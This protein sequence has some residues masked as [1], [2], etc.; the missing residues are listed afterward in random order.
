MF[1]ALNIIPMEKIREEY[2]KGKKIPASVKSGYRKSYGLMI[3]I[4]VVGFVTSI[5]CYFIGTGSLKTFSMGLLVG[6]LLALFVS[7]IV[8]KFLID[9]YVAFNRTKEKRV[10]LKREEGIDEIG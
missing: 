3:D 6:S 9:S 7:I 1:A 10:N 5:L 2:A 4:S 8:S